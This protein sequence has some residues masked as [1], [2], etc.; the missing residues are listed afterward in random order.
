[1]IQIKE[2]IVFDETKPITEQTMEFNNWYN[3]NINSKINLDTVPIGIDE[4]DR[5]IGWV[6]NADGF[7]V[8]VRWIYI[9][10]SKSSWACKSHD[11]TIRKEVIDGE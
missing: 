1:M 11:V 9:T 7:S 3:M 10:Q 2:N 4:Y 8:E 5:P 6:I